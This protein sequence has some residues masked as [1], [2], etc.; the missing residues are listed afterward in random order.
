VPGE[1]DGVTYAFLFGHTLNDSGELVVRGEV[2]GPGI[3]VTNGDRIWRFSNGIPEAVVRNGDQAAGAPEG[4][5]YGN[6]RAPVIN[7]AGQ[8]AF[9]GMVEGAG[10]D[11]DNDLAVWATTLDGKIHLI[12]RE[13]DSLDVSDIPGSPDLRVIQRITQ[14]GGAL[15]DFRFNQAGQVLL[16]LRFTDGSEGIFIF[17]TRDSPPAVPGDTNGDGV[18][19]FADLNVVLS[20]FGGEGEPG[21]L[22]GD[23]NEDGVVNFADL[24]LVLSNFGMSGSE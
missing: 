22:P 19:N 2:T 23:T 7:N 16:N 5:R 14:T 24:N 17:D 11:A 18:V 1:A 13:G 9:S 20:A 21:M 6:F 4:I 12:A 10:V 8:I 3:N 15:Q